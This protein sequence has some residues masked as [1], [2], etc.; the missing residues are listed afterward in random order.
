MLMESWI[1]R[2]AQR[3]RCKRPEVFMIPWIDQKLNS[4]FI[5][6]FYHKYLK[7]KKDIFKLGIKTVLYLKYNHISGL[8]RV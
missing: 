1:L 7:Y 8:V 4:F 2:E 6:T 3:Q 5:F